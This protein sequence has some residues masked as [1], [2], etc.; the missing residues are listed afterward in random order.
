MGADSK[1]YGQIPVVPQQ[2]FFRAEQGITRMPA[3]PGSFARTDLISKPV[4]AQRYFAGEVS[5][6]QTFRFEE[7]AFRAAFFRFFAAVGDAFATS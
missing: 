6:D 1:A 4:A 3:K 2:G 5:L 7:T